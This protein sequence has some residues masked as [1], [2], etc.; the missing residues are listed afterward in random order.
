VTTIFDQSKQRFSPR[1]LIPVNPITLGDHLLLNRVA[2]NLSQPELAAKTGFSVQKL[3]MLE[4]DQVIPTQAEWQ[5]LVE[6][7]RLVDC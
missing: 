3:K 4:H 7:L 6:V 5:L 1:K 2:A